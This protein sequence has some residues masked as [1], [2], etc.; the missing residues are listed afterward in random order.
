MPLKQE[1]TPN[2]VT[3]IL[4]FRVESHYH[5]KCPQKCPKL[6]STPQIIPAPKLPLTIQRFCPSTLQNKPKGCHHKTIS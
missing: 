3:T 2:K 5:L 4:G 6:S 1:T